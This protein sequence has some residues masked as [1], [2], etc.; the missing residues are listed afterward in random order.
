MNNKNLKIG[1]LGSFCTSLPLGE[2]MIHAPLILAHDLSIGLADLGHDVTFFGRVRDDYKNSKVKYVDFGFQP[3]PVGEKNKTDNIIL[4][5][6]LFSKELYYTI[7]AIKSGDFDIFYS[8]AA[9]MIAPIA[10][11]TQKPIVVTHH[12]STNM[13]LYNSLFESIEPLNLYMIPISKNMARSIR[14]ENMLSVVHHGVECIKPRES[15]DYF[16]WVGRVAPSKGLHDAVDL[17]NKESFKLKAIGP[18]RG[19][20]MDFGDMKE[21]N[22]TIK[23]QVA[24][25]DRVEL[26]GFQSFEKT[27]EIISRSKGLIFPTTGQESFGLI[28]IEAI[29]SGVPVIAYKKGPTEEL[30]DNGKT[31][32]LCED[33]AEMQDAIRNIDQIDRTECYEIG[34][35]RFSIETMAKGYEREFLKVV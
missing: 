24:K 17:A 28:V 11:V 8:W 12:D 32:F 13:D 5:R 22:E 26:M 7:K 16:V 35:K 34:K 33:L 9:F 29:T 6:I 3:L 4:E 18:M 20:H 21:Y 30:I 2:G 10:T 1:V 23:A 14:Y 19:S 15:E 27:R 31:G 25:S